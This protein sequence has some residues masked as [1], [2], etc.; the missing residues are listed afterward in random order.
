[1]ENLRDL[2]SVEMM[3]ENIRTGLTEIYGEENLLNEYDTWK[4]DPVNQFDSMLEIIN[5]FDLSNAG[6]RFVYDFDDQMN[7]AEYEAVR[8][9]V[10]LSEYLY[11]K[12]KEVFSEICE[13]RNRQKKQIIIRDYYRLLDS[14]I[15]NTNLAPFILILHEFAKE[16]RVLCGSRSIDL[17]SSFYSVKE[18]LRKSNPESIYLLFTY[19]RI[20]KSIEAFDSLL[21]AI[22]DYI[23][24][25]YDE[26]DKDPDMQ[27]YCEI[28]QM[29]FEDKL[30]TIV[31]WLDLISFH[32]NGIFEVYKTRNWL[33]PVD[34]LADSIIETNQISK[35]RMY[36]YKRVFA[37]DDDESVKKKA[38]CHHGYIVWI[39]TAD[40]MYLVREVFRVLYSLSTSDKKMLGI[41]K[42]MVLEGLDN[43][44]KTR[45]FYTSI[46][47]FHEAYYELK[48]QHFDSRVTEALEEDAAKFS[49][50]IDGFINYISAVV[51]DD[52][53]ELL[54]AKQNYIHELSNYISTEQEEKLDYLSYRI[55]EK[56]KET[57]Q[58]MEVYD[59]L[60]KS[61][62]AEFAE[63]SS[64]LFQHPEIL[65]SLV[66]AEYLYNQ[67]IN[68][69]QPDTRFDYSCISIMYYMALEDF[70]NKLIYTPYSSEVLSLINRRQTRDDFWKNNDCK[71]YV[72]NFNSFWDKKNRAFKRSCEIGV[73]GYLFEGIET[74][75]KFQEFLNGKYPGI[76]IYALKRL[77]TQ[78]KDIAPRRND[79]AHGGNYLTTSD[80]Q[81][82]KD[83]VYNIAAVYKGLIVELLD[84][85]RC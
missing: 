1:M 2:T 7:R 15:N 83:Y 73:L 77:G 11:K 68:I 29:S 9:S 64:L 8:V 67:Y 27:L 41:R 3:N 39:K 21:S 4:E 70:L 78:L 40:V 16:Q 32:T 72:S 26:F 38:V 6:N 51:E 45:H 19:W 12:L 36:L 82:D 35:Y 59:D 54:Q 65:S 74:E 10:F 44:E 79:A 80:V 43:I 49:K 33:R 75:L 63:Y 57:I 58:K 37:E 20:S 56:L 28:D 60:Y 34:M 76:D 66:S 22:I 13:E 84:I 62:S 85:I 47:F 46:V 53:D 48:K 61:V 42:E 69:M 30:T 31:H 18:T 50:S 55:A 81:K 5:P 25:Y 17:Y 24:T 14:I 52:I 71:N 23:Q